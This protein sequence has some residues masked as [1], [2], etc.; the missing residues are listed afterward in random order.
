VRK[1]Y[2]KKTNQLVGALVSEKTVNGQVLLEID[3]GFFGMTEWLKNDCEE[4]TPTRQD[5]VR[6]PRT[7]LIV[8]Y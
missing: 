6:P 3:L 5:N 4:Y 7:R 2:K 8:L 1:H